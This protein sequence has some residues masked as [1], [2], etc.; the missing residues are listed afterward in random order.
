M[1]LA[2][3]FKGA[4]GRGFR[5]MCNWKNWIWPGVVTTAFLTALTGW[6]WAGHVHHDL[7]LRAGD[8]L[9]AGQPWAKVQFSGR[10]GFIFGIAE[11]EIQQREAA[12]IARSTYGV[13]AIENQTTLP[14]KA[15]P[16]VLSLVKEGEGVTLK[17]NYASTES[18]M[19]LV[20]AAE[21]A[22]PGIAI[23]D[24]LT[25]AAGKPD[26]FDVLASFGVSQLADLA[27][28]EVSLSN[29]DYSIKGKPADLSAYETLTTGASMLP[30]G[31]ALKTMEFALP[32]LG[33]PYEFAVVVDQASINLTGYAP[34]TDVKSAIESKAKELFAGK[35]VSS[36][37]KLAAGAPDGFP[38]AVMFGMGQIAGL[39][40]G[41]FSLSDLNYALKG[42]SVDTATYEGILKASKDDLPAGMTVSSMDIVAPKAPEPAPAAEPVAAFTPTPEAAACEALIGALLSQGQINFEV[43]EAVI[44]Q[45][46]FELLSRIVT[47][48]NS[49]PG[50]KMEIGGHTDTD[51]DTGT[52]Q[53]LSE[54]RANAVRDMLMKAGVNGANLSA[55]GYGS[56]KPIA[57][58]DTDENKARNRRIEFRLVP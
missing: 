12:N 28:G 21:K 23:K 39:G 7:G 24:E 45:D 20:A 8:Q 36:A 15:D 22:M 31:G 58:N 38:E 55:K 48:L 46:S 54:A 10:D 51:G 25:L 52:N 40:N 19:A 42:T 49:C 47:A 34:S 32:E 1:R 30:G 14:P 27:S 33:K 2:F 57:A 44:T 35:T 4:S 16:F 43:S 53:S 17:G 41:S 13:R 37:L 26:G 3:L 5:I 56:T 6:F 9:R 18:R 29:L 50:T 11:N